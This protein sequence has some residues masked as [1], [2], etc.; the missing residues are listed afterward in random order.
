MGDGGPPFVVAREGR[1]VAPPTPADPERLRDRPEGTV[2]LQLLGR[3][4]EAT[5]TEAPGFAESL[6]EEK[7]LADAGLAFER[8]KAPFTLR[9]PG[10]R[11]EQLGKLRTAA[12]ERRFRVL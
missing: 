10:E 11:Q 1:L 5:E 3:P 6:L 12:D 9:C 4:G 8:D 2:P 7:C